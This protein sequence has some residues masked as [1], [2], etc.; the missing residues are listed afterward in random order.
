MPTWLRCSSHLGFHV[1][2]NPSQFG[3][4]NILVMDE[5]VFQGNHIHLGM[6]II[7]FVVQRVWSCTKI[8][9]VEWKDKSSKKPKQEFYDRKSPAISLLL[10]LCKPIFGHGMI[11]TLD[12]GCCVLQALL[13]LKEHGVYAITTIK[14]RRYWPWGVDRI[15]SPTRWSKKRFKLVELLFYH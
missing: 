13:K 12:S 8:E 6:N 5:C 4:Q 15:P 1:L 7:L 3:T 9:L 14:M 10:R 11:V 2:M